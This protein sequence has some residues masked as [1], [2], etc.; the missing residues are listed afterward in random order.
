MDSA[1]LSNYRLLA[2]YNSWFNQRLYDHLVWGDRLP[3]AHHALQQHQ[4]DQP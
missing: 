1:F 3:V 2:R 4:Q